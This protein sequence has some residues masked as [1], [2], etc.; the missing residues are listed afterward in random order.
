VASFSHAYDVRGNLA[1]LAELSGTKRYSYD[2]IERLTA[3]TKEQ[4]AAPATPAEAYSYD[5]EGNRVTSQAG[6]APAQTTVTDDNNRVTD[7]GVNTYT[8][9]TS[10]ALAGEIRGQCIINSTSRAPN[11]FPAPT[12]EGR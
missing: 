7:D 10:N 1:A 6:T 3:V 8:W 12:V 2:Q 11:L 9:N 5:G 4:G